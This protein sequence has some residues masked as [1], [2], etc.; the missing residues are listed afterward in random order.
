MVVSQRI[1]VDKP[2]FERS[3]QIAVH[4]ITHRLRQIIIIEVEVMTIMS[5]FG[6]LS[7]IVRCLFQVNRKKQTEELTVAS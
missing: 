2:K 3:Y 1:A 5:I 7:Q 6:R 4:K